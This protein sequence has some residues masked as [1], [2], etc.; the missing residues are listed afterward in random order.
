METM[1][2]GICHLASI[3]VRRLPDLSSEMINQLLFGETFAVLK[4]HDHYRL[5]QSHHDGYEG[6]VDGRQTEG[7][8]EGLVLD[9]APVIALESLI[10]SGVDAS[11]SKVSILRGSTLPGYAD[12]IFQSG[13]KHYRFEG[14]TNRDHS[15]TPGA[16]TA[17]AETYLGSPYLWGGRSPY[18]IDCSGF[19]QVVCRAFGCTLP[20]DASEQ[21]LVGSPVD[22]LAETQPG[23]LVFLSSS[24]DGSPHVG[25]VYGDGEI[26]HASVQV[27]IGTLDEKGA[28]NEETQAYSHT[29]TEVRRVFPSHRDQAVS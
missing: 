4:E 9:V 28:F 7:L 18:G 12:G 11:S 16:I 19:V 17:Y 21:I 15:V 13:G 3:P 20:R 26:I 24:Y 27:R 14:P 22:F 25:M 1:S 5:I 2:S 29:L 8:P 6:W 23:D 10:V